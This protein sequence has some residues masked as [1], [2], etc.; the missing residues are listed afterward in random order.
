[1]NMKDDFIPKICVFKV[2][3]TRDSGVPKK[4]VEI[5]ILLICFENVSL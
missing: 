4:G 2:S 3:L 1:M 5:A